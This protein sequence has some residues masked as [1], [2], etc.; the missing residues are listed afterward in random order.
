M[1]ERKD[2]PIVW[3][4]AH[5][6][7]SSFP[8]KWRKSQDHHHQRTRS[9]K[10]NFVECTVDTAANATHVQRSLNLFNGDTKR[11]AAADQC[12]RRWSLSISRTHFF[13]VSRSMHIHRCVPCYISIYDRDRALYKRYRRLNGTHIKPNFWVFVNKSR[14][15]IFKNNISCALRKKRF[16]F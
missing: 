9:K 13:S 8:L 7:P 16:G 6:L 11:E 14:K 1:P 10:T 3:R 4:T 2:K 12:V 15:S 5:Q